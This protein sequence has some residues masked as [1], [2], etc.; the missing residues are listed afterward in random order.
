MGIREID[1]EVGRWMGLTL[2]RVYRRD[3]MLALLKLW[4]L[5]SEDRLF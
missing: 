1:H 3:W 4:V 2:D 5:L